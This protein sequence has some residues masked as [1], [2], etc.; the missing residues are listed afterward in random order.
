MLLKVLIVINMDMKQR[1]IS[2]QKYIRFNPF[3]IK[4]LRWIAVF[5]FCYVTYF[6]LC[7]YFF[8][9]SCNMF[10]TKYNLYF[11]AVYSLLRIGNVNGVRHSNGKKKKGPNLKKNVLCGI[12][13]SEATAIAAT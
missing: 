5:L 9:W 2:K 7:F 4:T 6:C 1:R 13:L 8:L 12:S 11:A 10:T 3:D